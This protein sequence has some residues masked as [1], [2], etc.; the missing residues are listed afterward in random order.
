MSRYRSEEITSPLWESYPE[1]PYARRPEDVTTG[2]RPRPLAAVMEA[3]PSMLPPWLDD[4]LRDP[5]FV[6]A[7][8]AVIGMFATALSA[9]LGFLLGVIV[10]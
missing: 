8:A 7:G 3:E 9:T 4:A 5:L 10:A 6:L 2:M 1:P